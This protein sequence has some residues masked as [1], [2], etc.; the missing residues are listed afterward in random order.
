[1]S[2]VLVATQPAN[3]SFVRSDTRTGPWARSA[4]RARRHEQHHVCE[5]FS[6]P[7]RLAIG[8]AAAGTAWL[9]PLGLV[10]AF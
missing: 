3:L 7:L 6:P 1:M 10:L 8:L 5:K 4:E 9:V 2:E